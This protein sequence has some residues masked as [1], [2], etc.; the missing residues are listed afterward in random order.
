MAPS[1]LEAEDAPPN[2]QI[3]LPASKQAVT[4]VHEEYQYLNL[5]RD[6]LDHGEHRPDRQVVFEYE[7]AL[8]LD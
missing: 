3:G 4:T 5:I 6:I 8:N 2:V 7:N 1:I